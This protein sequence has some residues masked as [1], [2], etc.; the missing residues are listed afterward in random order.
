MLKLLH[1]ASSNL[2]SYLKVILVVLLL[3]IVLPLLIVHLSHQ[4]DELGVAEKRV[5]S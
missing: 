4:I 5:F 1:L 2:G 3:F